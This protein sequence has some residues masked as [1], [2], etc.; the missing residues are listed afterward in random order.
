MNVVDALVFALLAL[1]DL[2][3]IVHLRRARMKRLRIE[4]M[5]RSLKLAVQRENAAIP[6]VPPRRWAA[7]RRAS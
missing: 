5:M 1:A 6:A 2:S 7:L 4:R 3:L